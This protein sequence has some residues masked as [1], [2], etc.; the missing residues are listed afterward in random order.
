[1][2]WN[3]LHK[4]YKTQY[5]RPMIQQTANALLEGK[6]IGKIKG[7][8]FVPSYQRGY[9]WT[10]SQ[11]KTLLDD[12]WESLHKPDNEKKY[13]LQPVVVRRRGEDEYE[14][15]D[16]QQR[17]T[18]IFIL[19]KYLRQHGVPLTVNYTIDYETREN[20]A[21]FL[22][23]INEEDADKN[24]DFYHISGAYSA[25]KSWFEQNVPDENERLTAYFEIFG[26]LIKNVIV[27][28]YEV[29][30]EEDPT[31]LF[32]R[33]NIG[34]IQLTNAELIR[35]LLL[36]GSDEVQ[37]ELSSLWDTIENQLRDNHDEFWYFMT[38]NTPDRYPSRIELLFDMMAEKAEDE[39]ERYYTFFW[40]EKEI[41]DT[42]VEEIGK[43][44][45]RA[46]LQV[47]EWYS[48]DTL[49]HKIG[50][51]ISSG[52]TTM[53]HLLA[54]FQHKRK[55]QIMAGLDQMIASSI[56]FSVNEG[57]TYSNLDYEHDYYA[58]SRLLL[59]FN[60]QSLIDCQSS[61]QRF[62]FCKYNTAEW[63]LEH[64][65]A[66][67]SKGLQTKKIRL[68]WIRMHLRS[69]KS[70]S[71]DGANQDLIQEMETILERS[72]IE[73]QNA[74]ED[75]FQRV[76]NVLSEQNGDTDYIHTISNM[77][78]LSAGDNAAL[79]NAT[80]DA[81]RELVI[82][83]DRRGAFIPYCTKM[84][85]LKYYTQSDDAQVHFWSKADRDAYV[86]HIG[87]TLKPYLDI[88]GKTF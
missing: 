60:V 53:S 25:I 85:F 49:Y 40:F 56:D 46:F 17:F 73:S 37:Q 30:L 64:I 77:A 48:D 2:F 75:L 63:S 86:E 8:F 50:Y 61:H 69:V 26:H 38:R 20:T 44:I 57:E 6:A 14:L 84:V 55:S 67:H 33:L 13:C 19:L 22:D 1:M 16:G 18:T 15:I 72:D 82:D 28:W 83:M 59:L 66:Q 78:L 7:K 9:R 81:K 34:R 5:K 4:K 12:L 23:N 52:E 36:R 47:R 62:P 41:K 43:K 87:N 45:E 11:V 51:L 10:E 27:I 39:K 76:C 68:E 42:G 70:I 65:H 32:T 35:A 74:F 71:G 31:A 24:I 58:I 21:Q 3:N 80:F 54:T 29:G 88:I 79:S